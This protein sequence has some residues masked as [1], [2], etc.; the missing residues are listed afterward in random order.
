M[1]RNRLYYYAQGVHNNTKTSKRA[2]IYIILT[3]ILLIIKLTAKLSRF[4]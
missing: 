3:L 1:R 4:H 2:T